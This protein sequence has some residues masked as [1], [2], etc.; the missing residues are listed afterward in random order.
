MQL[1][2]AAAHSKFRLFLIGAHSIQLISGAAH[3]KP[4]QLRITLIPLSSLS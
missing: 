3:A 2:L 1:I 4:S